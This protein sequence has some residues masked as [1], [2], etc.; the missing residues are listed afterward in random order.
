MDRLEEWLKQE[1]LPEIAKQ[2]IENF[3]CSCDKPT[4]DDLDNFA[5]IDIINFNPE[6]QAKLII[7]YV[8]AYYGLKPAI[9]K[10]E[11]MPE[12]YSVNLDQ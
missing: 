4:I 7:G 6:V 11:N 10:P 8:Y 2:C 12:C 1:N 9:Y 5:C 3:V